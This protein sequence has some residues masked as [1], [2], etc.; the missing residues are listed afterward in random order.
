MPASASGGSLTPFGARTRSGCD[1][2][3]QGFEVVQRERVVVGVEGLLVPVVGELFAQR[4]PRF[5]TKP[6]PQICRSI[7]V[8]VIVPSLEILMVEDRVIDVV[9]HVGLDDF[10]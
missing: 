7:E 10:C 1:F 8:V 3:D 4:K 2:S 5:V 6:L 9:T